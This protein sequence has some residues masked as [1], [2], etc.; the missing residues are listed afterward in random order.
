MGAVIEI[1]ALVRKDS[2]DNLHVLAKGIG[3]EIGRV[4]VPSIEVHAMHI[5]SRCTV[6]DARD[7]AP[8]AGNGTHAAR[9]QRAV[10]STAAKIGSRKG[11]AEFAHGDDLGMGCGVVQ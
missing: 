8:H 3:D 1:A 5:V 9:L 11:L 10:E 7:F 4:D 6:H 2:T